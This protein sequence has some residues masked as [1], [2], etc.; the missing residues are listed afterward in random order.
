MSA[1]SGK[2]KPVVG[3]GNHTVK[4]NEISYM[5]TPYD[6][7]SHNI[8]LH[9]ETSPV[10]GEFQGFL[11]DVN[12]QNGP[13]YEGQVGRVRFSPYAF[14]DTTLP[15]GKEIS[16]VDEVMKS[17]IQLSETLGKREA[18]DQIEASTI[19][20]FMTQAS[21]A[22]SGE[23]YINV[24]LASR[25]W[26]NKEGYVN[27]DLYLPKPSSEGV[28]MESIDVENSN[29]IKFDGNNPNHLRKAQVDNKPADSFEPAKT[30]SGSDFEF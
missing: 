3:P 11:K 25:E 26:V 19:E 10:K 28:A 13:R 18:L 4:I 17:M 14:K 5:V 9:V 29:I 2:I 23:V 22:L 6:P 16:K 8:I 15:N 20:D 21:S 7:D 27:N 24:C 12:N 1:G 30:E